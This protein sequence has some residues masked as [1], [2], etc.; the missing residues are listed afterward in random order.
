MHVWLNLWDE[1]ADQSK[2]LQEIEIEWILR[3]ILSST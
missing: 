3:E 2:N 1:S